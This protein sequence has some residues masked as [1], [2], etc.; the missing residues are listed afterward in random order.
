MKSAPWTS[1][2]R[3]ALT[4]AVCVQQGESSQREWEELVALIL[5]T[6]GQACRGQR[7]MQRGRAQLVVDLVAV[8]AGERS[9]MTPETLVSRNQTISFRNRHHCHASVLYAGSTSA[10]T[11]WESFKRIT[12]IRPLNSFRS[13]HLLAPSA[14]LILSMESNSQLN[15]DVRDT[16]VGSGME[17]GLESRIP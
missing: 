12:E 9:I 17:P 10:C 5:E 16:A 4:G 15:A 8:V 1:R 7:G 14:K 6:V 13:L 11:V 2:R 3:Q